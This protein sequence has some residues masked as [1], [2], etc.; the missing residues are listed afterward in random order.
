[1]RTTCVNTAFPIKPLNIDNKVINI[2]G[3]YK[4]KLM[5]PSRKALPV[6]WLPGL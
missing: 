5:G 6:K 3:L 4:E 1:M 2:L